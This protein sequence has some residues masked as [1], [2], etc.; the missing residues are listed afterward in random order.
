VIKLASKKRPDKEARV[1]GSFFGGGVGAAFGAAVGG[2]VGAAFGAAIG[3]L[4]THWGMEQAS[5]EGL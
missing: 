2:P 4:L 5:R 3:S 1:V